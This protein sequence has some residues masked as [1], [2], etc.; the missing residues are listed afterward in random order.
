[1]RRRRPEELSPRLDEVGAGDLDLQPS[2]QGGLLGST[3]LGPAPGPSVVFGASTPSV[4]IVISAP[5]HVREAGSR[6]SG[7]PPRAPA[8][9]LGEAP[10]SAQSG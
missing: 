9:R 3:R 10:E 8:P 4:W 5:E 2:T 6:R 7:S 1:L